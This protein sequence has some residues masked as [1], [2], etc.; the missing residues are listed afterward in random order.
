MAG[1][2][3]WAHRAYRRAAARPGRTGAGPGRQGGSG[4]S[5]PKTSSRLPTPRSA[6][7]RARI[8]AAARSAPRRR[9]RTHRRGCSA[10][11]H[12]EHRAQ[13]GR[14]PAHRR[15]PQSRR[16]AGSRT[17]QQPDPGRCITHLG[18]QLA[19]Q[20]PSA[21]RASPSYPAWRHLRQVSG[22]IDHPVVTSQNTVGEGYVPLTSEPEATGAADAVGGGVRRRRERVHQPPAV[23]RRRP[24]RTGRARFPGSSACPRARWR[25]RCGR[26]RGGRRRCWRSAQPVLRGRGPVGDCG[27]YRQ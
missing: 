1:L 6:L 23:P 7:Q 17:I 8:G 3:G 11:R 24:L 2:S 27:E 22:R 25:P 19:G 26:G 13:A 16:T 15:Q 21:E 18:S 14:P 9:T 12:R 5:T 20:A 10:D 4:R